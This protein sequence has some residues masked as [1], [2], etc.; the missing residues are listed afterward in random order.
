ME[1]DIS[2]EIIEKLKEL[3]KQLDKIFGGDDEKESSDTS[4]S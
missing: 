1:D 2:Q 4:L 3:N